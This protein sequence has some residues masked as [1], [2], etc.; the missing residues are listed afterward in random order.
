MVLS[1]VV[2]LYILSEIVSEIYASKVGGVMVSDAPIS[3]KIGS[4]FD[5][6]VFDIIVKITTF[7]PV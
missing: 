4:K 1:C 2:Y 3:V 7:F 5:I 6:S